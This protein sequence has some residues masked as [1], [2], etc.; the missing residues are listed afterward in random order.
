MTAP[1]LTVIGLDAATFTVIEPL[2]E[3]GQLPH[4]EELLGRAA[5]GPLRSTTHPLTPVAWTTM[6]TGVNAGRHGIWDFSDRGDSGYGQRVVNGGFRSA[7]AVWDHLNAAGR[8]VG[9][10]NVPFTWPAPE[11]DGFVVAGFDAS[12]REAGLTHPPGLARELRDRFG[13]LDLDHAFPLDARGDID[14]DRV[15]RACEQRVASTAFLCDRFEPELLVVVFMSADHIH[16]LCWPEW[17]AEGSASRVADVYRLLDEA[18]GALVG[19]L[20]GEGDTMVV[21]DH[22]GGA[23]HG[24]LNLNAWLAR[25]GYLHYGYESGRATRERTRRVGYDLF[26]LRRLLPP[27]LRRTVKQRLPGLRERAYRLRE[28]TA[29]DWRRTSVFSYG[30]FGNVVINVRGRERSGVVEQGA[31]YERLRKEVAAKLL[32]LRSSTGERIVQAVHPR[33]ELFQGPELERLPDLV[34]EFRDYAWLGKGNL[35]SRSTSI[36]DEIE[37]GKG[38]KRSYV[39]SHRTEGIF[40]LAGPSASPGKVSQA[41]LVDITPTLLYLLDEPIPSDLEGRVLTEAIRPGLLDERP[42]EFCEPLEIE[43]TGQRGAGAAADSAVESRLR[44]LGYLE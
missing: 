44:S 31:E 42:L 39:G 35:K 18:V 9:L 2:L 12:G 36:W 17:E 7:A 5:R 20:G 40:L 15:R 37:V 21:S 24:V 33:E 23:L 19:G 3:A 6:L 27:G 32:E 34:V 4:L 14:L 43:L 16:H 10:V 25:E 8:R 1:A 29:V 13:P 11:V 26:E 22:G 38:S 41:G 30:T 28:F